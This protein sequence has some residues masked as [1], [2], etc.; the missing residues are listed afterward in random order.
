MNKK[1]YGEIYWSIDKKEEYRE[2]QN[3]NEAQE[4][5]MT[6]YRN[7]AEQYMK[8]MK[9][10]GSMVKSGLYS[11]PLECYC[12]YL[13]RQIN[14]FLRYDR[15]D[16]NHTYREL[17][18]ILSIVLCSAPRIPCNLVLYRMVNDEFINMLV[19]ENKSDMPT[20]IQERGFMSTSL[21]KNIINV[22]EPYAAEKNL[23]KIYI[24]KDTIGVYVNAV[25]T[26]NE[27][28]MLLCPNMFLGLASYPYYDQESGKNVY[29]CQLINTYI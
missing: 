15:D 11:A 6:L 24:P 29:E 26:R 18:H 12:G 13:Y 21:L 8:V 25:T 3:A 5:G 7:W 14:K 16:Q 2:F 20:P 9:M 19:A 1:R 22:D 17:S 28:E 4:W 27:E 23:L 10:A